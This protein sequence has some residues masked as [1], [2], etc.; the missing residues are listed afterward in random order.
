MVVVLTLV[1][2]FL[3]PALVMFDIDPLSLKLQHCF[4]SIHHPSD[5]FYYF[6]K[7]VI[8]L[9]FQWCTLESARI[10][11]N[12]LVPVINFANMYLVC[13]RRILT[14]NTGLDEKIVFWYNQHY[15][16][17]Q[18]GMDILRKLGGT[19]M[20]IGFI[21]ILL[22]NWM[23]LTGWQKMPLEIY[24]VI[25]GLLVV[26]Y[27]ILSQTM[28]IAIRCNEISESILQNWKGQL[29]RKKSYWSKILVSKRPIAFYYAMT[30]FEIETKI[31]YYSNI[32]QYTINLILVT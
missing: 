28:P 21:L 12:V 9:V 29:Q 20:G 4:S 2:I 15:C 31:N 14:A 11:I 16:I 32:A 5:L 8:S 1:G 6:A 18:R 7:I 27:F 30:K 23:V 22:C 13:L 26:V 25:V 10:C 24:F 3:A 17:H 19:V